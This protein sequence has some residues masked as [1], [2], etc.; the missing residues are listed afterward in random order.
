MTRDPSTGFARPIRDDATDALRRALIDADII[1][2]HRLGEG[3]VDADEVRDI[4]RELGWDVQR[5]KEQP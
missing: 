4:L 5:L 1:T 2:E 3:L